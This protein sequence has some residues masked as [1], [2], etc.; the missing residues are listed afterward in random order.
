MMPIPREP[1][2]EYTVLKGEVLD[3]ALQVR[4]LWWAI[5]GEYDRS[6]VGHPE[7]VGLLAVRW[8]GSYA[9]S[10]VKPGDCL[11]DLVDRFHILREALVDAKT[12]SDHGH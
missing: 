4:S 11:H 5:F 1:E 12:P 3:H 7:G 2:F 9:M 10:D 8:D 6:V